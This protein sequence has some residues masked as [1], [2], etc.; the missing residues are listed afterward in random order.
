M[1]KIKNRT[2]FK[3]VCNYKGF[4]IFFDNINVAATVYDG[5][6][7]RT[8]KDDSL[9]VNLS[10]KRDSLVKILKSDIDAGFDSAFLKDNN[11]FFHPKTIFYKQKK[12]TYIRDYD[13]FGYITSIGIFNDM[14]VDGSGKVFLFA[15]SRKPQSLDELA[16]KILCQFVDISKE[17]ILED[18]KDF[19]DMLVSDGF[20]IKGE[21]VQELEDLD[22]GFSYSNVI[23]KTIKEDFSPL[24][25]RATEDTQSFLDKH[26]KGK[27]HLT[28]FQIELT[29]RCNE[30][31]VHCYIPHDLKLHDIPSELYYSVLE[32]LSKLGVLS[33]TLSGGE[34]MLH[35]KFIDFLLAAKKYDFYVNILSNLTL[36]N[37]QI[38]N[39]MKSVNVASVQVSLYSMNPAHHD[40]IT[41]IPGSFEKTKNAILKLIEND[42]PVHVSCPTMKANKNDFGDVLKWCHEHKIRAQTDY[43]I[44]AEFN[45]DTSNLSNRLSPE[46]TE[47]VIRAISLEDV[48]YQRAILKPDFEEKCNSIC[49]N[50]ERQVCGVGINTCCMV[51]N[52]NVY[53]CPGWQD[54]VLGNLNESS[55]QEIWFNSEKLNWLRNL[56]FKDLGKGKCCNCNLAAFCAPCLVRN[57]NESTTGNPLEIN[58]HFC[59]VAEINKRVVLDWRNARLKEL[60]QQ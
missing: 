3:L 50:P 22:L 17:V 53:P 15:L 40:A 1:E 36:L 41:T 13:G 46:E 19:Y 5:Y 47:D 2:E 24:I 20:L 29:S 16:N 48:D 23:P 21:S 4:S 32:Q 42:I 25:Q 51:S 33:I 6:I 34:P 35:P 30:R 49:F 39:A 37:D 56:R 18:A 60:T 26:F 55:L 57:A 11:W 44:M 52:G 14:V 59:K 28:S 7:I 31:C 8:I 54:F 43:I 45:H 12:D 10:Q 58:Q 9:V 38:I 27:P